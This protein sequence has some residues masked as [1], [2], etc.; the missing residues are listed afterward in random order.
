MLGTSPRA[1]LGPGFSFSHKT[2]SPSASSSYHSQL[3]AFSKLFINV[4][5]DP[6]LLLFLQ[7][8]LGVRG[9]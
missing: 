4:S 3:R 1:P 8:N 5:G 2:R 9:G 7:V 6:P